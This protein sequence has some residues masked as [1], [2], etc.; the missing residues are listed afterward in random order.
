[1][2]FKQ[3]EY[4]PSKECIISLS[5]LSREVMLGIPASMRTLI[6]LLLVASTINTLIAFFLEKH[7]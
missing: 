2:E 7:F 4:A 1:M 3:Q 6:V 5:S